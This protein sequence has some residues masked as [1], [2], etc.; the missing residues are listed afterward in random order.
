MSGA[1]LGGA[2]LG[3]LVGRSWRSAGV[4]ALGLFGVTAVAAAIAYHRREAALLA[5]DAGGAPADDM[6]VGTQGE[7][8]E[9]ICFEQST[10]QTA[11]ELGPAKWT[12]GVV[13]LLSTAGAVY[14]WRSR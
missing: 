6:V 14:L 12:V 1:A 9:R 2:A 10:T 7:D 8:M 11:R 5:C 13:G 3:G 4:G